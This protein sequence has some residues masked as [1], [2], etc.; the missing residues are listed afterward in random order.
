MSG[1]VTD[2]AVSVDRTLHTP[3]SNTCGVAES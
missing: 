2:I 1:Y 3:G